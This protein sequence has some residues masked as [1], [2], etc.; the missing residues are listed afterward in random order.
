MTNDDLHGQTSYKWTAFSSKLFFLAYIHFAELEAPL[1]ADLFIV[2]QVICFLFFLFQITMWDLQSGKLLRT[3]TDA[4]P[5]GSA[6]LHVMVSKGGV[7][8][9]VIYINRYQRPS[10]FMLVTLCWT[11]I[12]FRGSSNTPGHFMLG[13]L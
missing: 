10:R 6:V 11:S 8:G 13:I 2:Y 4:H 1:L 3:I 7:S 5:L 12:P 9:L